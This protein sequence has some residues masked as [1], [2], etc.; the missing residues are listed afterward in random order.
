MKNIETELDLLI[1]KEG[2]YTN[3]PKDSGGETIWGITKAVADAFGYT[4]SMRDM[5]KDQA[6]EIYRKRF[7]LQPKFFKVFEYS[8]NI[9]MELFD[10]GVNMGTGTAGK[11]LQKALNVLNLN[12]TYYPDMEVDGM[13]GAMTL[14]ALKVFLERRKADGEKV[15]LRMLNAI[16]GAK[17]IELAE[18]R[19]KDEAFI[20][21]W[22][23]NRVE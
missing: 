20:Y 7:W 18:S 10:T 4:G 19:P 5:S 2:G 17:Y 14:N 22:I 6:K 9:A 11:A 15:L 16:Q 3:N 21:G 12:G 23:L 8:P 1:G 13:I